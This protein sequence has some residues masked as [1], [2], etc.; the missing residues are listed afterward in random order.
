MPEIPEVP[1]VPEV[2][3]DS[4]NTKSNDEGT[5][6]P[7]KVAK[8]AGFYSA[9]CNAWFATS[10]ELDKG[11][12]ALSSGGIALLITLAQFDD[13]RDELK[14]FGL[15]LGLIGFSACA[16]VVLIIFGL[17]KQYLENISQNRT[18]RSSTLGSLDW[19]ARIL[20]ATGIMGTFIF[21]WT[22]LF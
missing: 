4:L 18:Q 13:K 19:Y 15:A 9:V 22:T 1:E 5:A 3:L 14:T 21:G 16:I 8:E 2:E 11:L 12:L 6:D 17:N 10:L 20:F 7:L